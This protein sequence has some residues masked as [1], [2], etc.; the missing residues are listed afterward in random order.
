MKAVIKICPSCKNEFQAERKNKTYCS[1]TCRAEVNNE[2]LR[3]KMKNLKTLE[4]KSSLGDK[5]KAA[6]LSAIRVVTIN[7][8]SEKDGDYINFEGNRYK[9]WSNKDEP[10]LKIGVYVG[11]DSIKNGSSTRTAIYVPSEKS[12]CFRTNEYTND[13]AT[14]KMV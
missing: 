3:D 12:L 2:K 10:L 4:S 14:F 6:Y 11:R 1:D 7:Y 13:T 5:Y 8:H 9:K